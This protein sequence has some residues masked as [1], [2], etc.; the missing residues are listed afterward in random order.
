MTNIICILYR[1]IPQ[2]LAYKVFKSSNSVRIRFNHAEESK[3]EILPKYNNWV[4]IVGETV[5]ELYL[6]R[7]QIDCLAKEV[8]VGDLIGMS[9]Q[10][11]NYGLEKYAYPYHQCLLNNAVMR[12]NEYIQEMNEDRGL[13]GP[14]IR[15]IVH[16]KRGTCK[17]EHRYLSTCHDGLHFNT[18][19]AMKV[20]DKLLLN[21]C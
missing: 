7:K 6:A 8:I 2:F 19:T 13:K 18:T 5:E 17:I 16:K 4:N 3:Y 14:Q 21:M 10:N 15:D 11:Y 12:I 1:I 9:F 20:M